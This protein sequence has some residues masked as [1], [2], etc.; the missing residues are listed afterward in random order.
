MVLVPHAF[1]VWFRISPCVERSCLELFINTG[2]DLQ[3]FALVFTANGT[4]QSSSQNMERRS[5]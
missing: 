4:H 2:D 1:V 3:L 5:R